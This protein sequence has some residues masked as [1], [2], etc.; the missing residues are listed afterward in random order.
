V[1]LKTVFRVIGMDDDDYEEY[2]GTGG[3]ES[4][5][6]E[7]SRKDLVDDDELSPQE[8]AF[9]EGYEEDSEKKE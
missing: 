2:E 3:D 6:D 8:E 4:I 1:L 7:D 9:M 5:Y